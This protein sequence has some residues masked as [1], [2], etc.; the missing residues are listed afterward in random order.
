MEARRRREEGAEREDGEE[1]GGRR[2]K[3]GRRP[4]RI[5][6]TTHTGFGNNPEKS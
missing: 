4:L 2:R 3:E 6:Q 1:G 5:P